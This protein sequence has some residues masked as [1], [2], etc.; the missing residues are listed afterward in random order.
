MDAKNIYIAAQ[1]MKRK[2]KWERQSTDSEWAYVGEP[3]ELTLELVQ[4]RIDGHFS[5]DTLFVVTDRHASKSVPRIGASAA[6]LATLEVGDAI[7][8]DVTFNRFMV[9][10]KI[11]VF[12]Q[13]RV[14]S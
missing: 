8:C 4:N 14:R 9:F 5:D 1:A 11:G 2:V 10:S 13:G 12:S 6:V 3:S 7:L